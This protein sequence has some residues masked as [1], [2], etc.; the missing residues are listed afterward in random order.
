MKK[1]LVLLSILLAVSFAQAQTYSPHKF[2]EDEGRCGE[3]HREGDTEPGDNFVKDIVSLCKDCHYRDEQDSHPVDIHADPREVMPLSLDYE[4]SIT[5]ATC[6][7]PHS[8]PYAQEPYINEGLLMRIR[9]MISKE[10]YKTFFLREPN[11]RGQI[12]NYCHGTEEM[13][14][15]DT[16]PHT[17]PDRDYRGSEKCGECH[18]ELLAAWRVT[19]HARTLQDTSQGQS[20]IKAKFTGDEPFSKDEIVRTIG[21]H[22]TQRYLVDRDGNLKVARG[23]WSLADDQWGQLYWREQSWR[24]K[25]AGCHYTGYNP[26]LNTFTEEGIGCEACHG[27]GGRHVDTQIAEFIVNPERLDPDRRNSICASCHTHGHDRTGEFRFPV[28]Y[29]PGENLQEYFKGLIPKKGQEKDTFFDDGTLA[30]RLRSFRFWVNRFLA[31]GGVNCTLCKSYRSGGDG[32]IR[33]VQEEAK[34]MTISQFCAGCHGD[35]EASNEYHDTADTDDC[36]SS[37][38]HEPLKDKTGAPSIHDHKFVFE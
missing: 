32:K 5:C 13:L 26:Y 17:V 18:M 19:I 25:C 14:E 8:S 23:V 38:C 9:G 4:G 2:M 12:C 21:N 34:D 36:T 29:I 20:V 16:V 35:M 7:D 6:H 10:G 3:C 24:E 28:G 11:N 1:L 30:D 27:P 22:W 15:Y 37:A 33:S 31:T